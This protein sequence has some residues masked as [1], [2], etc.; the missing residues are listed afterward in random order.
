MAALLRRA[1]RLQELEVH[2]CDV[3]DHRMTET[4]KAVAIHRSDVAA[5]QVSEFLKVDFHCCLVSESNRIGN[6]SALE[7]WWSIAGVSHSVGEALG[8]WIRTRTEMVPRRNSRNRLL[9]EG[10]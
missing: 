8:I 2:H 6:S 1:R 5:H 10:L 3:A 4:L 9:V 7:G